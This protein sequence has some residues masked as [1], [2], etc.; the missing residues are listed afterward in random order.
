MNGLTNIITKINNVDVNT[1]ED[2]VALVNKSRNNEI[3][4]TIKRN[5]NELN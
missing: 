1:I 5:N 4:F 2:F 3:K